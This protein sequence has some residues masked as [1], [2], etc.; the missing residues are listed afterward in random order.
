MQHYYRMRDHVEDKITNNEALL[1]DIQRN[2]AEAAAMLEPYGDVKQEIMSKI[3][4]Y[5]QLV[6]SD[7]N[8]ASKGKLSDYWWKKGQQGDKINN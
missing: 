2:G 5:I 6:N 8:N 3:Y 7:I 1:R 4:D